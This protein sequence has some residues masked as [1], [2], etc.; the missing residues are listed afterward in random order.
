MRGTFYAWPV[1]QTPAKSSL[2]SGSKKGI[3]AGVAALAVAACCGVICFIVWQARVNRAERARRRRVVVASVL[4]DAHDRIL[5][6]SADG[7]LPMCDIASLASDKPNES[8]RSTRNSLT[9]E[10]TVLGMD[11]TTGHEAFISACRMTWSWKNPDWAPPPSA[12]QPGQSN[13]PVPNLTDIRRGSA[14]TADSVDPSGARPQPLSVT[15]FLEKFAASSGQLAV[16]LMG[17]SNGVT[18]MGVLY[19][20]ILTT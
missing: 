15:R 10:N 13:L 20:Q 3:T 7:M 8:R 5:V 4:L 12:V 19:D 1:G 6:S 9:S 16:R 11:L 14:I 18:R 2:M 17:Q